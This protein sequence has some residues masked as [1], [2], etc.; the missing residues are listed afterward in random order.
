MQG[1]PAPTAARGT[2]GS[3]WP[4]MM[5]WSWSTRCSSSGRAVVARP[6][7]VVLDDGA[8]AAG[9]GAEDDDAVGHVGDFLDVVADH[10]DRRRV[11]APGEAQMS[12]TSARRLSAVSAST[13]LN[14]SSM[15]RISGSTARARAMPTRCFMPPE[16]SRG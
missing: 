4:V 13:W 9:V 14:G 5:S 15:K 1:G 6:G 11:A 10:Q 12:S 3:S 16:S 2:S 8:D 7:Q